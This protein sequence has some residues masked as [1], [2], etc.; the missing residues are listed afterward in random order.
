MKIYI[1]TRN[2]FSSNINPYVRTLVQSIDKQFND[3]KW[4][5]G[6]DFL[7]NDDVLNFD[8]VHFMWP[9]EL[10]GP[11]SVNTSVECIEQRL[12]KLKAKGVNVVATC[13]NLAPHYSTNKDEIRCYDLVYANADLIFHL[14]IYSMNLF[15]IKYSKAKNV[16]LYHH[17]LDEIYTN[18][19]DKL[20]SAKKLKLQIGKSYILCFGAFRDDEERKIIVE[21]ARKLKSEDMRILAPRFISIPNRRNPF[22]KIVPFIKLLYYK[23][24]YPE[25]YIYGRY[26]PD[27]II[28]F[29]YAASDISLIQRV[30]I[31]NSGN[32]PLGLYMGNVVVGPDTGNVGALLKESGNPVF[33]VNDLSTLKNAVMQANELVKKGMG[34][35][36]HQYAVKHFA[37]KKIAYMMYEYYNLLRNE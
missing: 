2:P 20:E 32:V 12:L 33:D 24:K 29:Y 18:H 11:M 17:V 1:V 16:L 10:V 22:F 25:I 15:K 6:F 7:W 8:I 13:H 3:V 21:L 4:E 23:F 26:I 14:G 30:H 27:E 35:I 37:T 5:F 19:P 31:L 9:G 36:N 28:P 34:E